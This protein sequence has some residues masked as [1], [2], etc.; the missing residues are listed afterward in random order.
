[1]TPEGQSLP[2]ITS[3]NRGTGFHGNRVVLMRGQFSKQANDEVSPRTNN[4][5]MMSADGGG[6][7]LA[8]RRLKEVASF[9]IKGEKGSKEEILSNDIICEWYLV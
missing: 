1:M 8:S 4:S 2:H 7:R 6:E 9:C 3:E 5:P